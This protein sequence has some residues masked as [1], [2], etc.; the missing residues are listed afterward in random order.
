MFLSFKLKPRHLIRQISLVNHTVLK[1]IMWSNHLCS[2]PDMWKS[3]LSGHMVGLNLSLS[4][5]S[6][7]G[8]WIAS[9]SYVWSF[10]VGGFNYQNNTFQK[11]TSKGKVTKDIWGGGC[12][13]S[14]GPC[15]TLIMVAPVHWRF[16]CNISKSESFV[17]LSHWNFVVTVII[18]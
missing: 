11:T 9:R 10:S 16:T 18:S 2:S 3:L 5:V 1:Y 12:S 15:V 13:V 4:G 6:R 7:S 8:Q 14:V 17:V